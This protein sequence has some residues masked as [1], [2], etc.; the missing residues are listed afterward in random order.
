M[1]EPAARLRVDKWLWHA[2]FFKSR[3]LAADCAG[4]GRLRVNGVRCEKP[5]QG[6][7]PGDVLTF[8]QGGRVRVIRVAA[9]GTRRGPA[10]EARTL[11]EDLE[12]DEPP[13]S[14]APET[15]GR[16]DKRERRAI[17]RLRRRDPGADP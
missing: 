6:V 2:R 13:A 10:P 4:S 9:L 5:A 12:P 17:E 8:P 16:P 15:E 1:T 7:A 3:A 14:Q 11:Y